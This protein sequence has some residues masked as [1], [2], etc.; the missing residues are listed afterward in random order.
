MAIV[1]KTTN[2][3]ELKD[4]HRENKVKSNNSMLKLK[5]GKHLEANSIG[6]RLNIDHAFKFRSLMGNTYSVGN[7][8]RY[9]SYKSAKPTWIN[10]ELKPEDYAFIKRNGEKRDVANFWNILTLVFSDRLLADKELINDIN[11]AYKGDDLSRIRIMP[12]IE[13]KRGLIKEEVFNDRLK[14]YGIITGIHVRLIV[15]AFREAFGE[16]VDLSTID[17]DVYKTFK[18]NI[19][20]KIITRVFENLKS[21]N[22]LDGLESDACNEEVKEAYLK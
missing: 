18:F 11:N 1:T 21:D 14:V 17:K 4:L 10:M 20:T 3:E 6:E 22:L 19:K 9:L 16:E 12:M 7:L 13:V 8:M 15:E 5:I 2:L